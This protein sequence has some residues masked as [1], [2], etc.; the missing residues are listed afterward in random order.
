M[1]GFTGLLPKNTY[2]DL[3]E[4][5]NGGAGIPA[6]LTQLLDGL[7][8]T[9]GIGLSATQIGIAGTDLGIKRVAAGVAAMTDGGG[10]NL[11]WLQEAGYAC[12][13][14]PFT[15][16]TAVLGATN[17]VFTL[18]AGRSYQISGILQ[19][20]NSTAGEGVQIDFSTGG[21]SA[22]TFFMAAQTVGT[23]VAG[24][25]VSTAL[26]TVLNWTTITGTDYIILM[27]FMKVNVAGTFILRAA[28][29]THSTGTLTMGAGSWLSLTDTVA[30]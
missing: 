4:L 13:A 1:A 19:V 15:N 23:V 10:T 5:N 26:A 9:T 29:N 3:I 20:S 18:K 21:A 8:N 22:T 6:T 14:A 30:L 28:E 24:T 16:A 11:A 27:G 17:L 7:G 25:V 12:L 2:G